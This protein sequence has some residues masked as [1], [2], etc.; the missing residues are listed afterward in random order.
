M[1]FL[2][3]IFGH[4][5]DNG[6]CERCSA[7]HQDHEWTSTNGCMEKCGI[8]GV[9]RDIGCDWDGCKCRRCKK[10]RNEGHQW[11][12]EEGTCIE[13][14]IVCGKERA[15]H[16]FQLVEIRNNYRIEKCSRCGEMQVICSRCGGTIW[17][18][19]YG[20]TNPDT[21]EQEDGIKCKNCGA[22]SF[23]RELWD[24]IYKKK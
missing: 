1:S 3:K 15:A 17:G 2:C 10:T 5:W 6:R 12:N 24:V 23:D 18:I 11:R 21:M 9:T 14:C 7:Y 13:K 19:F 22:I 16:D 20:W 8:C 4:K